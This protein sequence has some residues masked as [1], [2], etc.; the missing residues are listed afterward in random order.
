[1][2]GKFYSA[3]EVIGLLHAMETKYREAML[4]EDEWSKA[5]NHFNR[6]VAL[7]KFEDELEKLQQHEFDI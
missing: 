7:G 5:R 3:E 1:M 2:K 4:N 6:A